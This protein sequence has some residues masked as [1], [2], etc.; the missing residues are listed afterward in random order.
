MLRS[1]RKP[2]EFS[3]FS[4]LISHMTFIVYVLYS[5]KYN[6]IYIGFTSNLEQ[7]ILS[8]NNLGTKGHT[9]KYRPW[10]IAYTEE[11]ENKKEAIQREKVLKNGKGRDFIWKIIEER[12]LISA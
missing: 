6:K 12:G 11:F 3:G 4:Y 5:K 8:H 2:A 1:T 9:L 7:R 10:I